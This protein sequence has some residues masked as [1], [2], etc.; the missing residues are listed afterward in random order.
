MLSLTVDENGSVIAVKP[1]GAADALG[2][3]EAAA[4]AA[5]QWR[6]NPP[7]VQGKPVRTEFAVDI[8][9]TQ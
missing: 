6:T 8:P 9:F 7:R 2:F 1:R 5:R 3:S 4:S